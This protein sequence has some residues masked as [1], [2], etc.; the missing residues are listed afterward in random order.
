MHAHVMIASRLTSHHII[1]GPFS[2]EM[3][4]EERIGDM[5]GEGT[6]RRILDGEDLGV[7]R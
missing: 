1:T 5:G 7:P 2:H 3:S 4:H 6:G